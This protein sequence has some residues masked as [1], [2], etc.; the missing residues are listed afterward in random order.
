V[1]AEVAKKSISQ[2]DIFTEAMKKALDV[3]VQEA[4]KE[5]KDELVLDSPTYKVNKL[6]EAVLEVEFIYPVYPDFKIGDYKKLGV[7]YSEPKFDNKVIDEEINR[8]R[9]QNAL[10]IK[11]EK[12]VIENGDT[13]NFDFEGSVDGKLFDGGSSKGYELVIG[14][15]Q[16]IPGFEEQMIGLKADEEKDLKV[17]FPKEYHSEDLKGKEAVFKV[18]I[19]VVKEKQVPELNDEFVKGSG[20][21]TVK[22]VAELKAYLTDIKKQELT[23]QARATFMNEAFAKIKEGTTI[24]VPAQLVA[25]EMKHMAQQFAQQLTQ[26]GLDLQKYLEMT[27]MKEEQLMSQYK[28]QAESK[29]RDSLI[30]AEIAKLEKIELTDADYEAEYKKLAKV[31]GQ[32]ED[33][34]KGAINKAQM[35]IPMTNDKVIDVLIASN[36]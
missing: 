13:V 20:V 17:T 15:G 16:F 11:K 12:Q 30:F 36:K 2:A 22:T 5:L 27:G 35:Q 6:T 3:L 14:S 26:Q 7:K 33:G 29:L 31:Y 34:I 25:K 4:A 9:E 28:A 18:K 8:L 23:M 1:P 32:S 19:N 10:V 24:P 21:P